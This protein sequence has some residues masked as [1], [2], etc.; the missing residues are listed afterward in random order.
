MKK[1]FNLKSLSLIFIL[2]LI[3]GIS[4]CL[5][6][7]NRSFATRNYSDVEDNFYVVDGASVKLD[8]AGIRF[9]TV[10]R[11]EYYADV[12]S[13]YPNASFHTELYSALSDAMLQDVT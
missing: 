8:S 12:I 4:L 6:S 1:Y 10:I 11:K 7:P 5:T 9:A 2:S 3:C 13:I